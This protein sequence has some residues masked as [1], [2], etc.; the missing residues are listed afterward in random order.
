M[1][2]RVNPNVAV[3]THAKIT[4]GTYEDKF[5]IAFDLIESVTRRRRS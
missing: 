1:A 5:G 3:D 2:V 4:T